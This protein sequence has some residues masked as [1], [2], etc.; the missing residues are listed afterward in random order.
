[1]SLL[2]LSLNEV[3]IVHGYGFKLFF[4]LLEHLP[5]TEGLTAR[6]ASDVA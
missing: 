1:V 5:Q 2:P 3:V 6:S 4:D